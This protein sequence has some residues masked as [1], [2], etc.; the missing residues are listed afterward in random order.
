MQRGRETDTVKEKTTKALAL[1]ELKSG[2][3]LHVKNYHNQKD[4]I[5]MNYSVNKLL[6]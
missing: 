2:K 3:I 5:K 4:F 1:R 6:H